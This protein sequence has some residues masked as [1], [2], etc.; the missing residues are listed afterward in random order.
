[1]SEWLPLMTISIFLR[2][3]FTEEEG[4]TEAS[5]LMLGS[6]EDNPSLTSTA[7]D[8]VVRW[9]GRK[10]GPIEN[11]N[12]FCSMEGGLELGRTAVNFTTIGIGCIQMRR[13]TV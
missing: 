7:S 11:A 3:C 8:L 5:S 9:Q 6:A 10:G 2:G 13:C 4:D 12:Q 1:M